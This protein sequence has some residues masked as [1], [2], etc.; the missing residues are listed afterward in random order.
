LPARHHKSTDSPRRQ[1]ASRALTFTPADVTAVEQGRAVA[2]CAAR[3][4]RDR[5]ERRRSRQRLHAAFPQ[6]FVDIV[7]LK[8][9][10]LC[11]NG[12]FSEMPRLDDLSRLTFDAGDLDEIRSCR[13]GDCDIQLSADQI[14]RLRAAVDW[15]RPDARSHANQM[16]RELLFEYVERY[17][18]EGNPALLE[19]AD[20]EPPVRIADEL[21]LLVSHSSAV[22]TGLP[23]FGELLRTRRGCSRPA[24]PLLSKEQFGLPVVSITYVLIYSPARPNAADVDCVH[25]STPV[26]I[27]RRR[28]H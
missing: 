7:S 22:L 11:A 23:E 17:R 27:L 5:R 16:L 25:R 4:S 28:W 15:S 19:Y 18:R 8:H 1:P 10:R 26:A 20:D 24:I 3:P 12:K 6:R 13:V 14:R 21:R 2:R 9:S